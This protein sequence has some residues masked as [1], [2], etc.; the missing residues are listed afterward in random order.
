MTKMPW[1]RFFPSDWLGGTRGMSAVETGIY[2]TLI[3]TMYE[4]GEP[5]VE[6]H[7]RL[8][9]LCGASNSAFKKALETLLDEGKIIRTSSGLWNDRVEKEQVYL[10][11]KSEVGSRAANARWN[12]NNNENNGSEHAD[13]LPTQSPGNANQK[14]DTRDISSSLRSEDSPEPKKSAPAVRAVIELPATSNDLVSITD[15]DIDEWRNAFPAV[16]VIQQLRSMRQWLIAN[17]TR[18]KTKRGMRKFVVQWLAKRQD[19]GSPLIAGQPPPSRPPTV[20]EVLKAQVLEMQANERDD[21]ES[22]RTGQAY[23]ARQAVLGFAGS[24]R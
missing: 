19:Q 11:E 12:K 20:T 9:R 24:S 17:P 13:A 14:P 6:D 2:I 23:G 16:D 4:R 5:I 22:D 15:A 1:V 7:S 8:A 21:A 18:R 3:A 10:S